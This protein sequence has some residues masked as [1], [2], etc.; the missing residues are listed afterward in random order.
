MWH[1]ADLGADE[2]LFK[3]KFTGSSEDIAGRFVLPPSCYCQKPV[4]ILIITAVRIN[5]FF[6]GVA[7][8]E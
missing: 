2:M 1:T 8:L 3:I 6:D 7:Q 5:L 4:S